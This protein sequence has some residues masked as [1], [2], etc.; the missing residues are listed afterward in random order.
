MKTLL[1]IMATLLALYSYIPYF[2]DIF[3]GK[4]KPHAFSWLVWFLLTAIAFIAQIKD[5][6]QAGAW[7]TGFTAIV[8]LMIFIAAITRGEKNITR[9]DWLCL[10]GSF[11][12]MGLWAVTD[13]PL[14]AVL[15]IT[16]IDALGFAPTFR[17]AFR[18]P[19]EETLVTFALSAV[20][21]V[22][23]IAALGNYST[24][25][26]LYPAS[27][28]LMNGLFVA[29]LIIR[30]KQLGITKEKNTEVVPV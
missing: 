13:S 9:S 12:A 4:T 6:G 16:L 15:L 23:A 17:K 2:R 5:N 27:L 1:G 28:V 26:V 14:T 18:N 29:M 21:F 20:K 7:V 24:V 10:I 11:L 19:Q 30:R 8:A 3:A 22:I 25:T